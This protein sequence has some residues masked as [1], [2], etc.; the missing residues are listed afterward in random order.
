ME[1]HRGS[2]ATVVSRRDAAPRGP[3][4]APASGGSDDRAAKPTNIEHLSLLLRE[5][6]RVLSA[7]FSRDQCPSLLCDG[8]LA[9]Y[10]A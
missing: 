4:D 10:P 7:R 1:Q 3:R 5:Q 9:L 8:R 2:P 6:P